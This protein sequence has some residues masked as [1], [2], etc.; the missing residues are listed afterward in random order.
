MKKPSRTFFCTPASTVL[1]MSFSA[2]RTAM[3]A[4]SLRSSPTRRFFSFAR[5]AIVLSLMPCASASASALSLA[6]SASPSFVAA[7]S[8]SLAFACTPA[9]WA[10]NSRWM[11]SASERAFSAPSRSALMRAS[12]ASMAPSSGPQANSFK[13]P[14]RHRKVTIIQIINPGSGF[15]RFS[16]FEAP[17]S[18]VSSTSRQIWVP[19][20]R[21]RA[22]RGPVEL[23]TSLPRRPGRIPLDATEPTSARRP[24]G[25]R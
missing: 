17:R 13:M 21:F 25:T 18:R 10:S 7:A 12:R 20:R 23:V 5:S 22:A 2:A 8:I 6:R 19:G 3:S 1:C 15:S 16:M 4:V 11:R 14:T 24:R 9:I